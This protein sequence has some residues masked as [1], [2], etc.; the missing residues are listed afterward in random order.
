MSFG[1]S[2][3]DLK[4]TT[5]FVQ[6]NQVTLCRPFSHSQ[7]ATS[8]CVQVLYKEI[9]RRKEDVDAIVATGVEIIY[10]GKVESVSVRGKLAGILRSMC[11]GCAVPV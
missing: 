2:L 1:K 3:Q 9:I 6:N 10:E 11:V 8:R 5:I 7:V 4:P